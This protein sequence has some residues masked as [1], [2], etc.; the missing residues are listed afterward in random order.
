MKSL[1]VADLPQQENQL[2]TAFFLVQ[3]K[4]LRSTREG[5]PYLA[6]RLADRTGTVEARMWDEAAEAE[7]EFDQHDVVKVEANVEP[8]RNQLQLKIRRLRR[9]RAD[10][11]V[12]FF[13]AMHRHFLRGQNAHI[14]SADLS[15]TQKSMIEIRDDQPDLVHVP[16]DEKF[17][18]RRFAVSV[19]CA[20][21]ERD[22]TAHRR[23]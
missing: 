11:A 17:R 12:Q 9:A 13:F 7:S 6:L 22:H 16:F 14:E 4:S 5:K 3:S 10:D 18:R 15:E 23:D 21:F 1:Y 2:I 19:T 8:Y 20:V